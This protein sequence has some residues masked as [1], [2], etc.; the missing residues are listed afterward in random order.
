M[1]CYMVAAGPRAPNY[2]PLVEHMESA[3]VLGGGGAVGEPNAF[4][5]SIAE[6]KGSKAVSHISYNILVC[7]TSTAILAVFTALMIIRFPSFC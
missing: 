2:V 6:M 3:H 7:A 1:R 5:D 4:R